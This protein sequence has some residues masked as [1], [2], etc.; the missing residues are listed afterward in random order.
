[1]QK[2]FRPHVR[3]FKQPYNFQADMLSR[4][5]LRKKFPSELMKKTEDT[6]VETEVS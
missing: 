3:F 1:M 2:I 6:L 5:E 4:E